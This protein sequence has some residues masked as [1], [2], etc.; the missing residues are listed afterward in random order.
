[1]TSQ[2]FARTP[3]LD[4]AV[5]V[6]WVLFA[7]VGLPP[8]P[9]AP[10]LGLSQ[11]QET[12]ANTR[13]TSVPRAG[14][15]LLL[16]TRPAGRDHIR[17]PST[18]RSQNRYRTVAASVQQAEDAKTAASARHRRGAESDKD[19]ASKVAATRPVESRLLCQRTSAVSGGNE[20]TRNAFR[21]AAQSDTS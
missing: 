13:P 4:S 11:Y 18:T 8:G 19:V 2:T 9:T 3:G 7:M 10:Q 20:R 12:G 16:R 6:I 17:L 15:P 21:T 1:R 5:T 14:R